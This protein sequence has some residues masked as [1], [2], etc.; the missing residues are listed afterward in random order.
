[1]FTRF[2][3]FLVHCFVRVGDVVQDTISSPAGVVITT[4]VFTAMWVAV[5]LLW[6]P[7]PME[8]TASASKQSAD[9]TSAASLSPMTAGDE[10]RPNIGISLD[11][12]AVPLVAQPRSDSEP[13]PTQ[14]SVGAPIGT[15]EPS[16]AERQTTVTVAAAVRSP[17]GHARAGGGPV[18]RRAPTAPRERAYPRDGQLPARQRCG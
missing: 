18:R 6:A 8:P 2:A 4:G 15:G 10:D 17:S 16:D 5:A 1:M 14:N 13:T 3:G 12:P 9:A 7:A 11:P